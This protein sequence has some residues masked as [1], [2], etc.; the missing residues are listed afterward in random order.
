MKIYIAGPISMYLQT[1]GNK[2]AFL[3]AAKAIHEQGHDTVVPH[4]L[5][6]HLDL[7]PI[8][9][10]EA[11]MEICFEALLECDRVAMLPNWQQSK[12]AHREFK[13]A[14]TAKI[15]VSTILETVKLLR[16]TAA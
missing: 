4:D 7:D 14:E 12:G 8:E 16:K 13:L 3:D 9:D 11:I 5:I 15:P 1:G 2:T 6:E 10:Y